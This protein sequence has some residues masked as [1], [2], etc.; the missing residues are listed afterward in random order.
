MPT[1][2]AASP[3]AATSTT[4]VRI[5]VVEDEAIV[6]EDI[7]QRLRRMGYQTIGP[8]NAGEDGMLL[9][10]Q[11]RPDLVLMDIMLKGRMDGV[12]TAELI[13]QRLDLPVVFLTAHG[14]PA[15]F[16]RAKMTVPRGYLLKPFSEADLHRAVEIA[17]TQH[18]EARRLEGMRRRL[19]DTLRAIHEGIIATDAEGRISFINQA[20][21]VLLGR[22][23]DDVLGQ[24]AAEVMQL[25]APDSEER[26]PS[27]LDDALRRQSP[28]SH[29][30]PVRVRSALGPVTLIEESATPI[31]NDHGQLIGGIVALRALPERPP[32]P[33]EKSQL[34]TALRA[35]VG[36]RAELGALLPVCAWCK[37]IHVQD[38]TWKTVEELLSETLRVRMTHGI[39]PSCTREIVD[40]V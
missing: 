30:H 11:T 35:G 34:A 9:A 1:P 7:S 23:S 39:C 5:L 16:S 19:S 10:E 17:L 6:A 37:R 3:T 4:P 20:A 24:P 32:A 38:G 40:S 2:P 28:V 36:E 18:R 33:N 26:V 21:E 14:D 12:E 8:V 15:T 13:S 27:S 29:A 25:V 31:C 22:S